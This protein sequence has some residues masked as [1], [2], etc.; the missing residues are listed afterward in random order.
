[1]TIA[2]KIKA[3]ETVEAIAEILKKCDKVKDMPVIF[4]TVTGEDFFGRV[5]GVKKDD[6]AYNMATLIKRRFEQEAFE[7]LSVSGKCAELCKMDAYDTGR[8]LSKCTLCEL[9][10]I[11]ELL[12]ADT[13]S[14]KSGYELAEKLDYMAAI[15]YKLINGEKSAKAELKSRLEEAAEIINAEDS[16]EAISAVDESFSDALGDNS[17]PEQDI[18]EAH[19]ADEK[20]VEWTGHETL[21]RKKIL[22]REIISMKRKQLI[23]TVNK[24]AENRAVRQAILDGIKVFQRNIEKRQSLGLTSEGLTSAIHSAKEE[25]RELRREGFSLRRKLLRVMSA[26]E[27]RRACEAYIARCEEIRR[28]HMRK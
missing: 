25:Y 16:E 7:A 12:G 18:P 21:R 26:S 4:R 3:A 10:E 24:Y 13:D 11:A 20:S 27:I 5:I 23:E 22:K 15:T 1:M 9:H 19:I 2:E 17:H 8:F 28:R 6:L 14:V